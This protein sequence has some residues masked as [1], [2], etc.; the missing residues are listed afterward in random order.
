MNR[1]EFRFGIVLPAQR[2]NIM[3]QGECALSR[4]FPRYR[5]TEGFERPKSLEPWK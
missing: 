3:S 2:E 5:K 1:I 4:A